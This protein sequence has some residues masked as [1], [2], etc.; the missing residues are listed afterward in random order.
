M[1]GDARGAAVWLTFVLANLETLFT[2]AISLAVAVIFD[3]QTPLDT[4]L[5]A[6]VRGIVRSEHSSFAGVAIAFSV[7]TLLEPLYVSCGFML[8]VHRRTQLE[9]WDIELR[10]RQMARRLRELA[11][12]AARAALGMAFLAVLLL[13]LAGPV[14]AQTAQEPPAARDPAA[15]VKQVL[16]DPVFGEK[17]TTRRLKYVGPTWERK[18]EPMKIDFSWWVWIVEQV[19]RATRAT[20]WAAAAIALGFVLYYLARYVRMRSRAGAPQARPD[21]LF[22]LDVRAESLP[23]DV[24]YAAEALAGAGRVREALSLLYRGALVR[25]MD[26][27]LEYRRGDTEGDCL[28]RVGRSAGTARAAYFRDLVHAWQSL[29]YGHQAVDAAS[30]VGLAQGWRAA[31]PRAAAG[32]PQ[33]EAQPA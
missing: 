29:A 26:E 9:G 33:P 21:F 7:T 15:E 30:A 24:A 4:L 19:A 20:A 14:H 18:S 32:G 10:F 12:P 11:A 16:K 3:V 1:D 5:E 31:F 23:A 6:W 28:A 8:Y 17:A 27:G 22:G 25:F 2:V 13:P